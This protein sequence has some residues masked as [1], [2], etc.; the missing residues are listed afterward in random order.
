MYSAVQCQKLHEYAQLGKE[1]SASLISR[2]T[3]SWA[4]SVIWKAFRDQLNIFDLYALNW[5][6]TAMA[7]S[8]RFCNGASVTL[9]LLWRLY[10]FTKYDLLKQGA[11]AVLFSLVSFC[12]AFL[13]RF[14]LGYMESP[15][16]TS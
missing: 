15:S 4:H 12:F 3:F 13:L 6:D 10:Y 5:D 14:I 9:K 11:W 16:T 7:T 8:R 2:W 1:S